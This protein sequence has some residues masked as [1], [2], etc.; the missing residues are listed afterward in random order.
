MSSSLSCYARGLSFR[1]FI[2]LTP[3][4]TRKIG[5]WGDPRATEKHSGAHKN[6]SSHHIGPVRE[7]HH[8]GLYAV[9]FCWE[10]LIPVVMQLRMY[11]SLQHITQAAVLPNNHSWTP[12]RE[13]AVKVFARLLAPGNG[14]TFSTPKFLI[15]NKILISYL[16]VVPRISFSSSLDHSLCSLPS[17]ASFHK[18]ELSFKLII[19]ST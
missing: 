19:W 5:L 16:G 12:G 7:R 3:A 14:R 10:A 1:C 15:K 18:T 4:L 8:I 11:V 2:L 13:G 17:L 6:A 9:H